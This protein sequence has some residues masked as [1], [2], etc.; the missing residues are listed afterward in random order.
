MLTMM[1]SA[2]ASLGLRRFDFPNVTHARWQCHFPV[3]INR[4]HRRQFFCRPLTAF[5]GHLA[6][7]WV[8]ATAAKAIGLAPVV[9]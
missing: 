7:L 2:A 8:A 5:T 6:D 9:Q 3:P 4:C 1:C